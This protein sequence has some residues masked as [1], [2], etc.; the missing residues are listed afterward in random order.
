MKLISIMSPCFNERDNVEELHARVKSVMEKLPDYDYEHIFIDNC[1]TDG[2]VDVLRQLAAAD[3]RVKV[4]LNARNFGHVR[5]PFHGLL[6]ARGDA[7]ICLASDLQDP[8]ELIA[9]FMKKWEAGYKVVIGIKTGSKENPVLFGIRRLFYW[10]LHKVAETDQVKNF[11]GFGLFDKAFVDVIR[12]LDDPYPYFR[13]LI[14]EVGFERAEIEYTQ[15]RREK[16]KTK[17]NFYTLY[18]V[19]ML[20]FVNHSKLPL[21]MASFIGFVV[22]F[23]SLL[24][25]GGY[26]RLQTHLLEQLSGWNSAPCHRDLFLRR[27]A[28]VLHRDYR[29]IHRRHL[30]PGQE[31]AAGHRKREDQF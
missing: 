30:Y 22:A 26:F 7:V 4:I 9:E 15:L 14:T 17:N 31:K 19:A 24:V 21:R 12:K 8:P 10:L 27:R 25:A 29:R 16:G 23:M 5:S 6:Q 11:T 13:G 18:D 1:S 28:A 2:T 20:G 3:K